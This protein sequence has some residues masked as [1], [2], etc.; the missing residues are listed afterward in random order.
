MV[1][2]SEILYYVALFPL[3]GDCKK[4]NTNGTYLPTLCASRDDKGNNH[5][6][7][8]YFNKQS[9]TQIAEAITIGIKISSTKN[10]KSKKS[11]RSCH[12]NSDSSDRYDSKQDD[13]RNRKEKD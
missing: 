4:Y 3:T 13:G 10:K 8:L 5:R 6:G 2:S 1:F 12:Q 11:K 9:Y 7:G